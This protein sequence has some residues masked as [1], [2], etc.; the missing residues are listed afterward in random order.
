MNSG[1]HQS[2]KQR[3]Q[4]LVKDSFKIVFVDLRTRKQQQTHNAKWVGQT[5]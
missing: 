2:S 4:D 1:K 5:L 3:G